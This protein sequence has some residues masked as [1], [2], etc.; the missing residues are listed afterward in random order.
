MR[1]DDT[2][3][4]MSVSELELLRPMCCRGDRYASPGDEI[5]VSVG[6]NIP[7]PSMS[8]LSEF[9]PAGFC[10]SNVVLS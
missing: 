7:L 5:V 10:I 6:E 1:E 4:R 9:E 8:R 2:L 3:F